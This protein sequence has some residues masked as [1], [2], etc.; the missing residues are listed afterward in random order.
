[1]RIHITLTVEQPRADTDIQR[2]IIYPVNYSGKYPNLRD[3]LLKEVE[4]MLDYLGIDNG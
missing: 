1:M 3:K 2:T 4:E